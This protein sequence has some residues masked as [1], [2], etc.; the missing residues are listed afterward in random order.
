MRPLIQLGLAGALAM[1]PLGRLPA[2]TPAAVPISESEL[3]RRLG[4]T[5]D[6][7]SDKGQ[8]SGVVVLTRRGLPVFQRATGMADRGAGRSNNLETGFNLGS[9]NKLFTATAVRQ[10]AIAG[11]LHLDSTLATYWPDYPNQEVARRVTIGQLLQHRSGIGGNI[12]G[13]LPGR[14][15]HDLRHN[16]DYL[17]LFV[18]AAMLFA[19]GTDE[20]YSNA[21]Y[22]VLGLLV[23]RLSGEDYYAYVRRHIYQPA[24]MTRTAAYAVD[25]LPEN[26]ALGYTRGGEDAPVTAPVR[27]NSLGLPGRGSAAGGGYST[28]PDLMRL[29]AAL[30]TG[31]IPGAPPGGIGIAGGADGLNAVVEGELRG[32]FDLIVLANLDPPAAERI[33]R[34]VRGWLGVRDE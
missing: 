25:S 12:F 10:L 31:R 28:A 6:S 7:L 17:P 8:F 4:A 11:K 23:E 21:G 14:S 3:I 9:I 32:E 1:S 22:V 27:P 2:Q 19:P 16:R 34:L 29:L 5:L 13:T 33:A 30:K 26:A 15:R 18:N 20:R 24:G